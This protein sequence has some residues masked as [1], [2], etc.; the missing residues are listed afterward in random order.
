M[1]IEH[2]YRR[3]VLVLAVPAGVFGLLAGIAAVA[4]QAGEFSGVV[5]VILCLILLA[6]APAFSFACT[7]IV[8]WFGGLGVCRLVMWIVRGFDGKPDAGA[9]SQTPPW[10]KVK[11]RNCLKLVA[12][13][14]VAI[15]SFIGAGMFLEATAGR[16]NALKDTVPP[17]P[18]A[19]VLSE[20]SVDKVEL[21][22][23]TLN[24]IGT[25]SGFIKNASR[26]ILEEVDT[27]VVV[28]NS[29]K[30]IIFEG[31][32]TV[33]HEVPPGEARPFY[34]GNAAPPQNLPDIY[35]RKFE[36]TW[37]CHKVAARG[38]KSPDIWDEA[39]KEIAKEHKKR[40]FTTAELDAMEKGTLTTPELDA[41]AGGHP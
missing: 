12:I 14:L 4:E 20:I 15:A 1:N 26:D 25:M 30:D 3:I 34:Y 22:D 33:K 11:L 13:G 6:L 31:C 27:H 39:A 29:R 28:R 7:G 32:V 21:Y 24:S 19:I 35:D 8:L 23:C 37:E 36:W 41:T 38:T 17:P 18:A 2:G 9:G 16:D 5:G 40:T 10:A